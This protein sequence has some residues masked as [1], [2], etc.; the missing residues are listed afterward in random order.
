MKKCLT[1][2]VGLMTVVTTLT[3]APAAVDSSLVVS[4]LTCSPG[5]QVYELYG[6]TGLRVRSAKSGSD[7]VFNY[8]VFDFEAPHFAWRFVLGRTDYLVA[9]IPYSWF[10]DEYRQRGSSITE[11]VL[12]LKPLEAQNLF[13]ALRENCRPEN[14]V[15]RYNFLTNNCTTKVRDIIENNVAGAVIYPIRADIGSF[16]TVLHEFTLGHEWARE[17]ND[18]LLG[19]AM[20]TAI[21]QRDSQ[22]S[23]I[24]LMRDADKAMI[25]FRG[26]YRPLVSSTSILLQED[27]EAAAAYAADKPSFP[28]SPLALSIILAIAAVVM[29]IWEQMRGRIFW[30]AD[31][32][33]M[34]FQGLAG[35]V[36]TIL[37][38]WSAHPGVASNWQFIVLNPFPLIALPFVVKADIR[39]TSCAYHYAAAAVL[40]L[41]L[42]IAPLMNQH[43]SLLIYPIA[44]VM[45][46]RAVSHLNLYRKHK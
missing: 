9:P 26:S 34:L 44:F 30:P 3:A 37:V 29:A 31:I 45:L 36:I 17:G 19:A 28:I 14:R 2:L 20:D 38:C 42:A 5:P 41:F 33:L 23:P 8:G 39:H 21:T 35:I 15:Y 32:I 4:L 1:L 18:L 13:N 10:L 40:L 12:N 6:H 27:A 25:A 11:Q 43:F 22:F 7:L 24:Y 16:R 46:T